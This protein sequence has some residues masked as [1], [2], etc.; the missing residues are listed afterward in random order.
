[1]LLSIFFFI[2]FAK[3][4]RKYIIGRAVGMFFA[5]RYLNNNIKDGF[6]INH[7]SSHKA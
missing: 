2:T 1:M 7:T 6:I 4:L 5:P 3:M